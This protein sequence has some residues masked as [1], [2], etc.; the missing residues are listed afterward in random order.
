MGNQ[1]IVSSICPQETVDT[2]SPLYGYRP[3]VAAIID[4][5]KAALTN[6]CL[7]RKLKVTAQAGQAGAPCLILVS[8]PAKPGETCK[9]PTCDAALGP[10][11][12][13]AETLRVFGDWRETGYHRRGR[14]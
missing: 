10:A 11:V 7:P 6:A 9:A 2:T 1:G 8:V 5:L 13:A 14:S 12:A 4:R 3:A